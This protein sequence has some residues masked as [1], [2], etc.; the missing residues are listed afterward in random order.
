MSEQSSTYS[1]SKYDRSD[2]TIHIW[3]FLMIVTYPEGIYFTVADC[4]R[5]YKLIRD[6]CE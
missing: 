6:N 2:G 4:N 1:I 5:I 3:R